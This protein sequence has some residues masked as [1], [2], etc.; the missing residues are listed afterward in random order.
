M[1]LGPRESQIVRMGA[2]G[3]N[4]QEI[5]NRLGIS[6]STVSVYLYKLRLK[7]GSFER[8]MMPGIGILLGLVTVAEITGEAMEFLEKRNILRADREVMEV[9]I[10]DDG[11]QGSD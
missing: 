11:P 3:L 5:A 8:E 7:I 6:K 1:K 2:L 10:E 4:D 9:Q